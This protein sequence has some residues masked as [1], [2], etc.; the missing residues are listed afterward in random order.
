MSFALKQIYPRKFPLYIRSKPINLISFAAEQLRIPVKSQQSG[1][2]VLSASSSMAWVPARL[3]CVT[4]AR[5]S[6]QQPGHSSGFHSCRQSWGQTVLSS[7]AQLSV[8]CSTAWT[9]PGCPLSFTFLEVMQLPW[10]HHPSWVKMETVLTMFR[11]TGMLGKSQWARAVESETVDD[12]S[13]TSCF[14]G[15]WHLILETRNVKWCFWFGRLLKYFNRCST[16]YVPVL[17]QSFANLALTI[18]IFLKAV[19]PQFCEFLICQLYSILKD[20]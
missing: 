6:S 15:D 16:W 7:A 14:Q 13:C 1:A 5:W 18:L 8:S 2:G 3:P 20:F 17:V 10:Y 9:A 11:K 19:V 4:V 12:I